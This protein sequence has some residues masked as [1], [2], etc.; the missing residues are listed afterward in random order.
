MLGLPAELLVLSRQQPTGYGGRVDLICMDGDGE[1]WLVEV[2]KERTPR[3]VVAQALDYGYW[4]S[5][6]GHDEI[7]D[8]YAERH[9]GEPLSAGFAK[10][11]IHELPETVNQSHHLVIVASQLDDATERIVR[12]AEAQ[13]MPINVVLFQTFL[14]EGRRYLA[15]SWLIDPVAVE[16]RQSRRPDSKRAPWNGTDFSVNVGEGEDRRWADGRRYGYVSAGGHPRWIKSLEKLCSSGSRV[17]CYVPGHG[18]VGVGRAISPAPVPLTDFTVEQNGQRV[19]LTEADLVTPNV[20]KFLL[21]T[22]KV[23]HFVAVDWE[24]TVPLEAAIQDSP[25]LYSNQG[26]VTRLRDDRTRRVVLSRLGLPSEGD[27]E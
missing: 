7:A 5:G 9:G 21:D 2:K 13:G 24:A 6:L 3:E 8:L 22:D 15:R 14:D 20:G 26:V 11:F 10:R 23:E 1:L 4:V 18:Y 19:P 27:D 12:Y 25:P 17:F 16:V